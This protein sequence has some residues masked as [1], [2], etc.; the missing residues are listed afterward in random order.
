MVLA[1]FLFTHYNG[2]CAYECPKEA[3]TMVKEGSEIE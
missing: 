1:F 3:I 2:L